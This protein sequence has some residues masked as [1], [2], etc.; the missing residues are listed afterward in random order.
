[1]PVT[2]ASEINFHSTCIS[3]FV[4][5]FRTN[6]VHSEEYNGIHTYRHFFILTLPDMA[7]F[8]LAENFPTQPTLQTWKASVCYHFSV[9]S[10]NTSTKYANLIFISSFK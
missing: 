10:S 6:C 2:L 7:N 1:M 5:Y 8:H 3:V 4:R 9:K